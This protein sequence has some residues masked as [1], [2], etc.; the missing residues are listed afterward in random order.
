MAR[1][2]NF[3]IDNIVGKGIDKN[4][5]SETYGRHFLNSNKLTCHNCNSRM[6]YEEKISGTDQNPIFSMC[7]SK[8]KFKLPP[9]PPLPAQLL[10]LIKQED[11]NGR[12][13][14]ERIRSYNSAFAFTSFNAKVGFIL[15]FSSI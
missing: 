8:A 15:I 2:H 12:G 5:L 1:M 11:E 9:L 6:F 4:P 3:N 7:C 13:F 10:S 14:I